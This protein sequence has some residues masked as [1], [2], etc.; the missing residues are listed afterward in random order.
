MTMN[1]VKDIFR[2][3]NLNVEEVERNVYKVINTDQEINIQK[4]RG[5]L[6]NCMI[7]SSNK[8]RTERWNGCG[9]SIVHVYY[10]ILNDNDDTALKYADIAEGK[11]ANIQIMKYNYNPKYKDTIDTIYNEE[12]IYVS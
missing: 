8:I 10:I 9:T 5:E 6:Q 2:K 4:I 3:Y 1:H 12:D 7:I 11:Y